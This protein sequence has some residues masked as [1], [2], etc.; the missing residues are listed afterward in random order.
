MHPLTGQSLMTLQEQLKHIKYILIDEMSFLGPKLLLKIDSHLRQAFPDSQHES[1]GGVSIILVGDLAQ[2]P[3]VMDKPIYASHSV[4]LGL[5]HSFTTVITLDTIFRQQGA[6]IRQQQFRTLLHNIRNAQALQHDWQFLMCQTN[7][8][9]TTQ[10]KKDFN[11][12][13]HLFAT[14]ESARLHN[15]KMLKE[16]NLPI[17]LS[18]AKVGKQTNT[19]Y[20]NDEQLPLEVLLSINQQVM[21]I[22]N[23]WIEVGLVNGAIGLIK[24]IVYENNTKP[25]DLPKY[26]V[27]QFKDYNGP[28]WDIAHPKDIPILP[29]TQ[30][31]RTQ[32]PLTMSWAITIHK[33][34]GLTL[35]RAT[36]DIGNTEKQGLTFTAISRVKSID[37]I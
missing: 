21:L 26:V 31:R 16:L 8:T 13:I 19:E 22:A 10:Q 35:D 17:A 20:D 4:A 15:R 30:G 33:S 1:F 11:S 37:G 2:L 34:Q 9:L 25:P 36:I 23:L 3:P 18:L 28:P 32:V 24:T 7:A 12:S 29:I 5:W 6:S 27:M 14:N